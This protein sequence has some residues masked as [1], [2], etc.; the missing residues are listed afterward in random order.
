MG[1]RAQRIQSICRFDVGIMLHCLFSL[2]SA[3]TILTEFLATQSDLESAE[4]GGNFL[5]QTV[6]LKMGLKPENIR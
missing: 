2:M 1:K 3:K 4:V 5:R 6:T